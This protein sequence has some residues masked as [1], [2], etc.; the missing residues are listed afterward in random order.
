VIRV[1]WKRNPDGRGR[2]VR[3]STTEEDWDDEHRAVASEEIIQSGLMDKGDDG[4]QTKSFAMRKMKPSYTGGVYE[5]PF[6]SNEE[7]ESQSLATSKMS[8][9]LDYDSDEG[10]KKSYQVL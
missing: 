3:A 1:F 2:Y 7:A 4:F 10:Q 9:N 8:P 6:A 5:N